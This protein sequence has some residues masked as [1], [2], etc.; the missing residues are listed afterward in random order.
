MHSFTRLASLMAKRRFLLNKTIV[1]GGLLS[2]LWV[3]REEE[4]SHEEKENGATSNSDYI[5]F[6]NVTACDFYSKPAPGTSEIMVRGTMTQIEKEKQEATLASLYGTDWSRP[7]GEGGFG[8]VYLGREVRTGDKGT[9]SFFVHSKVFD[10]PFIGD[11][12]SI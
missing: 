10:K 6:R 4:T 8:V 2:A 12:L 11:S 1:A 5:L 9:N 3:T 7:L